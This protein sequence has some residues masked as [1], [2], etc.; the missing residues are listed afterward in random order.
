[1]A[2]QFT[3]VPIATQTLGSTATSI[4][5]SSIPSTYQDIVLVI[6]GS[7]SASNN[8]AVQINGDTGSNYSRTTL[9][10]TGSSAASFRETNISTAL[11]SGYMD[12]NNGTTLISFM[13]Y[14]NTNTYK[15]FLV[16]SNPTS[17]G[18][19]ATVGLWR[20]TAA[21]TSITLSGGTYSSG[22]SFSIYGLAAA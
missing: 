18:T 15:T 14:A 19:Y 17:V 12:T 2:V 8:I 3:Y 7:M 6:N 5:F 1:M 22:D 9:Y 20:S 21:I 10:G 16:R 4:T 13:A 11:N